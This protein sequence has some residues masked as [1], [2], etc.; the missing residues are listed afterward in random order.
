LIKK[1]CTYP[2]GDKDTDVRTYDRDGNLTKIIYTYS[3]G[4]KDI[5]DYIYDSNGNLTKVVYTNSDGYEEI[6]E[7]TYNFVYVP[8]KL[9]KSVEEM[10]DFYYYC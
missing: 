6:Y 4:D 7:C 9:S 3:N 5:N 8:H 2:N 10:L 1:V